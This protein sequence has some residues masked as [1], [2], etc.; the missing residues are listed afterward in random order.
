MKVS[1]KWLNEYVKVDDIKPVDL[2]EKIERTAVEVDDVS[3]REDGQK[4]IVV[5]HILECVPHPNS[6]HLHICQ[7]DVGEEEPYQI[8]CGAPNVK[9]GQN[10]IVALPNS[11]IAGHVKIK[12]GKMRGEIS[13]GMICGLQEIGFPDKIVPEEFS[14]G[15]YVLPETAI[16]GD[17][18]FDYLGMNED[19]IDIDIT[20]N[21][22]DMLSMR[23]VAYE[24]AAIYNR[25]VKFPTPQVQEDA[26][27]HIEDYLTLDAT[28]NDLVSPYK[29]RMVKNVKVKP[30][31]LWLQ[32]RLWNAGIKPVNNVVDVT[33][34]VLMDYGQPIEAYDFDKLKDK[35]I[36]IRY[37]S[38]GEKLT[39][40]NE[41]KIELKESDVVVTV[42]DEPISLAGIIGGQETSVTEMT[43][44]VVLCAAKYNPS[45]VRKT[46]RR[47][48][49]HSESSQRFERGINIQTIQEAIDYAVMLV[50]DLCEGDIISDTLEINQEQEKNVNIE[51]TS[52]RINK[53][54]GTSL[55]DEEIIDIFERL[56]FKTSKDELGTLIVNVPSRRWDIQIPADLIE[57]V[58]RIYGY[59]NIPTTLPIMPLTEGHYTK[60][61]KIIR[62]ARKLLESSGLTQ[63]ISYGLTTETKAKR[64]V[65]AESETTQLD[66][67]MSSDHTTLRMNL[68]SG[69]LDD[70]AYNQARKVNNVALYEQGRV[71]IRNK[72]QERP[73]DIEYI[74]GALSGLFHEA[75]WHDDKKVVDF[76]LVKGIVQHLL[77]SL[78]ITQNISY[79][80]T[81]EFEEM[82]PGRTAK[83]FINNEFIGLI[84]EVHPNLLKELKIKT[85][86][87][88]ELDLQKIIELPKDNEIYIPI[89]KYPEIKRDMALLVPNNI[90]NEQIVKTI[91]KNGGQYLVDVK[92]FDLY[93]G[94]NIDDGFKSL[95][96][97]LVYSDNSGTLNDEKVND[98]FNKVT[99][100]LK[101]ELNIKVR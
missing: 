81:D 41:D 64:F 94:K 40:I 25:N 56:G 29:V 19:V 30:S 82:H 61:Q 52:E 37:A 22:G 60:S 69:L 53:V 20:P 83:I 74:A 72:D 88:F 68:I 39:T 44:N 17:S 50:S 86:Y 12:K 5:G 33:N 42:N 31:P 91:K 75:T 21:R 55:C 96:Y 65:L 1:T 2:G 23:G 70:V 46:A 24:V 51:I 32:R 45:L 62:S 84:G 77:N 6:D 7:V 90:T 99:D 13:M 71:F 57:E 47:E 100:K 35:E 101:E 15:I 28:S 67:P 43:Q 93:Q 18:I 92:L 59:D 87:I 34:Y 78:G 73:E 4:K 49:I 95:A 27:L 9:K 85:T 38:N 54:L 16:P 3:R 48:N 14:D 58:A 10:V 66:F 63:A 36:K 26:D 97:T 8:V 11:W 89:S 80:A 98:A 79:I 76:Y